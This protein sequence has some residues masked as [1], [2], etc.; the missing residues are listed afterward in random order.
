MKRAEFNAR[1]A[2]VQNV[3]NQQR[4]IRNKV[5]AI[6]G[7]PTYIRQMANESVRKARFNAMGEINFNHNADF[8]AYEDAARAAQAVDITTITASKTPGITDDPVKGGLD[9]SWS[10]KGNTATPTDENLFTAAEKKIAEKERDGTNFTDRDAAIHAQYKD[11]FIVKHGGSKRPFKESTMMVSHLKDEMDPNRLF[12]VRQLAEIQDAIDKL[13]KTLVAYNEQIKDLE[14][15]YY[16]AESKKNKAKSNLT[17]AKRLKP[18]GA[19][20]DAEIAGFESEVATTTAEMEAI[21]VVL[22]GG[23]G[24]QG[25]RSM[26][27]D[28]RRGIKA[29]QNQRAKVSA[30]LGVDPASVFAGKVGMAKKGAAAGGV[31]GLGTGVIATIGLFYLFRKTSPSMGRGRGKNPIDIFS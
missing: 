11:D 16:A 22:N 1:I 14:A 10:L 20:D 7:P 13:E 28:V 12:G 21:N 19:I 18:T 27:M 30:V 5:A 4:A 26:A 25:V 8:R 3:R 17:Y 23:G 6:N 2:H 29:L 31:V 9:D 15:Q 24:A